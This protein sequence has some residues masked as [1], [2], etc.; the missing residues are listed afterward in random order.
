MKKTHLHGWNVGVEKT[1]E[2]GEEAWSIVFQELRPPTGD[3]IVYT[4]N[5][6]TRDALVMQLTGGLVLA[7]GELPKL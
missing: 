2:E 4:M 6:K 7:G 5:R 1:M 3:M